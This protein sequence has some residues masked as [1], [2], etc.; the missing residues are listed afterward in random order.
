MFAAFFFFPSLF[1]SVFVC[2]RACVCILDSQLEVCF[3]C[4]SVL[5]LKPFPFHSSYNS[6][7]DNNSKAS[8]QVTT[9]AQITTAKVAFILS[10][11]FLTPQK[12]SHKNHTISAQLSMTAY[13]R[14]KKERPTVAW[15]LME[16]LLTWYITYL[17]V[18]LGCGEVE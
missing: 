10:Y 9:R 18:N 1:V 6:C 14:R 4:K 12:S 15:T 17:P 16:K 3:L 7:T 8:I 13:M 5:I 11:F 2:T